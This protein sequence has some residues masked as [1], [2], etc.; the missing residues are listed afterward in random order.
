M[1][2]ND[3]LNQ[4]LGFLCAARLKAQEGRGNTDQPLAFTRGEIAQAVGLKKSPHL[5]KL[6]EQLEQEGCLF[7]YREHDQLRTYKYMATDEMCAEYK[8]QSQ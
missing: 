8:A 2:R 5:N 7:V 4:I 6:L 3:R 1:S